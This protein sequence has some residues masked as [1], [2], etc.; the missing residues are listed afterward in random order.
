MSL[1]PGLH[2]SLSDS[3][4][5]CDIDFAGAQNEKEEA[6]ATRLSMQPRDYPKVNPAAYKAL[7]TVR[8]TS[9]KLASKKSYSTREEIDE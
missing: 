1:S 9:N 4:Q 5:D 6:S 3:E 7:Y 2:S 8:I